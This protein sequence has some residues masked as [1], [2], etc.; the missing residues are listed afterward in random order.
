MV[1]LNAVNTVKIQTFP[2]PV[3]T[4]L[5]VTIP[6]NWQEKTTTYEIY[7]SSGSL[8]KRSQI[9]RAAQVQQINVQ[10]LGSGNYIIRV[11]NG[12]EVSSSKFVKY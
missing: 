3:I 12:Q 5:R 6:A 4:E 8:V 2:N 9:A 10:S 11:T 7:N 1:R